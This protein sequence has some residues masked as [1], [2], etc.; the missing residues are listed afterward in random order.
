AR[1]VSTRLTFDPSDDASPVWSPDGR[2]IVFSSTREGGIYNLYQK[3]SSGAGKDELLLKSGNGKHSSDWS[4]DGRFLIYHELGQKAKYDIWVLPLFGD[5]K[6]LPYLVTEFDE[7]DGAFSPDGKW[8]AYNSDESGKEEVFG[9]PI[10][11][12]GEKWQIS[13]SGG[14]KPK[15]RRDGKE[16]FYLAADGRLRAVELKVGTEFQVGLPEPLFETGIIDSIMRYAV[17][18]DGKRF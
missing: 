18:A 7:S 9:Q 4:A 3:I 17:T 5:R 1:G 8:I 16:L 14:A 10:P 6:P 13:R 15:W 11:A 2:R 12:T